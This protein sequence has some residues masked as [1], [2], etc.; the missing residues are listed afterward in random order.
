MTEDRDL[1]LSGVKVIDCGQL[2]AGPTIGMILGDFG[3]DVIKVEN[4]AGGDPL[5]TFGKRRGQ[6]PLYWKYLAR[7]KRSV[8]LALNQPAGQALFRQLLATAQP[9][10][11]IESFRPGTFERWGLDEG[12]LREIVPG[13]VFVRVSGYGQTGPYRER[14]GFGT[15]AEA[16]SGFA[17]MTGQAD[18]PPTLPPIPLADSVAALYATIGVLLALR[19]RDRSSDATGQTID[20]SLLESLFSL[21]ANQLLEFDQLGEIAQ[22][23]G[24]RAPTSA[25]R[26][27]YAT[28]DGGWIAIAAATQNVAERL[29]RAIGHLELITDPKFV[30]NETRV[31]NA[32]PLD[33]IISRWV[34][35][36]S[37]DETVAQLVA[38]E[39]P[40]APVYDMADLAEDPHLASRKAVL[41][42]DDPDLGRMRMPG[43]LPRLLRTP[44]SVRTTA[45]S[46]G[47][48]NEEVYRDIVGL[49][50]DEMAKLHDDGVI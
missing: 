48:A 19:A 9:D 31:K 5:R 14:P 3:A 47:N 16:M 24:N 39:V 29:F 18:G 22:R 37:R 34:G 23:N 11:V 8:T 49:T 32:A 30:S 15:L 44:G 35:S 2:I 45:P 7:N 28:A 10:V 27:L 36:R 12:T 6:I 17:H 43:V 26:N 42:V 1:P 21:Q 46:Q 40:V 13:V 4:P 38:A 41:E 33:E 25:P 50:Q 20:V